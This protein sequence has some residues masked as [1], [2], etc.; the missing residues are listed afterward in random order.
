MGSKLGDSPAEDGTSPTPALLLPGNEFANEASTHTLGIQSTHAEPP[1]EASTHA[2][3]MQSVEVQTYLSGQGE[4]HRNAV[5][6]LQGV[7]IPEVLP[8]ASQSD[9]WQSKVPA[10]ET[11]KPWCCTGKSSD[12]DH[13]AN[14]RGHN[15]VAGSVV[16]L[17]HFEDPQNSANHV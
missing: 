4:E 14:T 16:T 13:E 2:L 17:R 6:S 8:V 3:S 9:S 12:R 1:N 5:Q 7:A 11:S 10:S 15:R